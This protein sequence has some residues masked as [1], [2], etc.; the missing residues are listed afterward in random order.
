VYTVVGSSTGFKLFSTG[1]DCST[2]SPKVLQIPSSLVNFAGPAFATA[3]DATNVYFRN[4]EDDL[5]YRVARNGSGFSSLTNDALADAPVQ[6]AVDTTYV[7]W[8]DSAAG[9]VSRVAI[10]GSGGMATILASGQPQAAAIAVDATAVYWSTSTSL[11]KL[12]K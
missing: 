12:A 1:P 10:D 4:P 5:L 9:T 11:M 3:T 6:I 8:T 7:Y 2:S